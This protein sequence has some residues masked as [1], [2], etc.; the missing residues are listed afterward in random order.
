MF[1]PNLFINILLLNAN[2]FWLYENVLK[3]RDDT[4][5]K[6]GLK[7]NS[8]QSFSICH[9]KL[10]SISA[11]NYIKLSL[12][13]AAIS[14]HKFDVICCISDASDDDKN[15]KIALYNLIR[16]DHASNTRRAG[17]CIYYK[18]S[19]SFIL[20]NIR[21]LK[22][23]I[24]CEISFGGNICNFISLIAHWVNRLTLF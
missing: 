22:E 6:P 10:N 8:N 23:R 7:P 20:L 13:R 21:Y 18:H 4:E 9:W 19:L 15:L 1:E 5:E 11:Y 12:L 24:N 17:V 2:H 16:A 14:T 3:L